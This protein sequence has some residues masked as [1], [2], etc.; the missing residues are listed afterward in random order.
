MVIEM[1]QNS[2]IAEVIRRSELWQSE[3]LEKL[4][5]LNVAIKA[6]GENAFLMFC[7]EDEDMNREIYELIEADKQERTILFTEDRLLGSNGFRRS[8]YYFNRFG[9]TATTEFADRVLK[10]E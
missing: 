2:V 1:D 6:K 5:R 3:L 9:N 4:D 8:V 10:S 7:G